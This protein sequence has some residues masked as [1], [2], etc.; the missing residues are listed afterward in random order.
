[1][2]ITIPSLV[3][4][5]SFLAQATVLAVPVPLNDGVSTD[6]H[7]RSTATQAFVTRGW[8]DPKD[9]ATYQ[10]PKLDVWT[11]KHFHTKFAQ[12]DA[13]DNAK[14]WADRPRYVAG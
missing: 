11:D 8:G 7:A 13:D 1:M 10:A 4:A 12:K 9:P 6:V 14:R 3:L 2:L 5:V